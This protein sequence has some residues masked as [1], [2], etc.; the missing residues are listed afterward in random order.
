MND[1]E[2]LLFCIVCKQKNRQYFQDFFRILHTHLVFHENTNAQVQN[3]TVLAVL[4]IQL[5]LFL[6]HKPL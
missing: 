4:L 5:Y 2:V 3:G 1:I 6:L